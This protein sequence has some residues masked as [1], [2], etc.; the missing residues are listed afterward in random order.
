MQQSDDRLRHTINLLTA[1]D[2]CIFKHPN[3][4]SIVPLP[5]TPGIHLTV[6]VKVT[7]EGHFIF[8]ADS[9]SLGSTT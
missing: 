1:A 7:M 9:Y 5:I 3:Q 6:T 4:F 8:Y 2:S